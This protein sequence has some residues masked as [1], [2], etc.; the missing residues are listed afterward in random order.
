MLFDLIPL[1]QDIDPLFSYFV[2][3]GSLTTPNCNENVMWNVVNPNIFLGASQYISLNQIAVLR[4]IMNQAQ[5]DV[6]SK[7]KGR[8]GNIRVYQYVRSV[9][10]G[11]LG[12]N[13]PL[14]P[15]NG[16]KIINI[17]KLATSVPS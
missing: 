17:T 4:Q 16:R 13:R 15:L 12:N 5:H 10:N 3:N 7:T 1:R 9:G 6:T 2:Y 8:G 14:Q 11:Y